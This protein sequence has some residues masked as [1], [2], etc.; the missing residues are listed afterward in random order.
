MY[1][2]SYTE[3]SGQEPRAAAVTVSS[4]RTLVHKQGISTQTLDIAMFGNC[5]IYIMMLDSYQTSCDIL[6]QRNL[7]QQYET[8]DSHGRQLYDGTI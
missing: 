3:N 7:S 6:F 4:K 8:Q 1:N 5:M 2:F